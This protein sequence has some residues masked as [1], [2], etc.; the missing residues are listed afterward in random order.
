[1][2]RQWRAALAP[3]ALW[4]ALDLSPRSGVVRPAAPALAYDSVSQRLPLL[5]LA[6]AARARGG[7]T[8]LDVSDCPGIHAEPRG[9]LATVLAAN[10]ALRELVLYDLDGDMRAHTDLEDVQR[11]LESAPSLTAL[12]ADVLVPS[13]RVARRVLR[14]EPPYAPLRLRRLRVEADEEDSERAFAEDLGAHASLTALEPVS[15]PRD[16]AA[17]NA[18][19]DAA[20]A[21]RLRALTLIHTHISVPP[22]ARLLAAGSALKE[23]TLTGMIFYPLCDAADVGTLADALRRSSLRR[24]GS[25]VRRI[26]RCGRAVAAHAGR[27]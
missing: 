23:L 5:L 24:R 17:L 13:W 7:L 25:A 6:A 3:A 22:L 18:L 11:L 1:M 8:F 16:A 10:A 12:R 15:E 27:F 9:A 14:G 26:A 2:C 4:T 19:V 20:L 21:L